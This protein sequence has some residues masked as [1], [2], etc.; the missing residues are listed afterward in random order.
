MDLHSEGDAATKLDAY[1][2]LEEIFPQPDSNAEWPSSNW[3]VISTESPWSVAPK[4]EDG[5]GK[6]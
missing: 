6:N 2:F 3:A 1:G 5:R 4:K